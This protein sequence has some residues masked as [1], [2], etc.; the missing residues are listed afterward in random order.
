MVAAPRFAILQKM[1]RSFTRHFLF[2]A[3]LLLC[4]AGLAQDAATVVRLYLSTQQESIGLSPRD[5]SDWVVT[6]T[7]TDK[8]ELTFV[9]IQ[10]QV[11]GLPVFGAVANFALREGEVIVF[12]DRLQRGLIARTPPAVPSLDA[13]TALQRAATE[14][15]LAPG[16]VRVVQEISATEFELL[17]SGISHDPIPAR[18]IYQPDKDGEIR[19]AWRLIIRSV[20][21]PNWWDLA[22]DAITGEIIRSN[23]LIVHCSHPES[24]S[25][26]PYDA[27]NDL[28]LPAVPLA[29]MPM[30]GS[31]YR[32]FPFPS[33]S[34]SHGPHV[35]VMD[36][37]DVDASPFGWHDTD[38]QPGGEFTTTRGNNVHAYED[39]ADLD[40]PGYS[41]DGGAAL[42]FDFPFTPPQAPINYLDASI[43]N[44]FH[45]CNVLHDVLHRYGFDEQSGNFQFYNY[46]GTG[47]GFDEVI[48]EAQ[49]GG[50]MNNA[51][52]GTP[53]D[54]SNG[55]MQMYLW[56]TSGD[57]TLFV[58]SPASID[59]VYEN[60]VA[61]FGPPLPE[62]PITADVVL[63]QDAV[64]PVND[65]CEQIQNAAELNG[66]IA[67]V[68]RGQCTFISKVEALQDAGAIAV[69]IVNNVPGPPVG[70][71]GTGG[72]SI[73]IPTVMIS[74]ANGLL[75]KNAL[76]E[77]PVNAT[78]AG[79]AMED[80]RD[81]GFDNGIIAHEYGHG[82]SNR[83]TGGGSDVG[84]LW[85]EEQM[86]EGWSDYLGMI[87]TML[88]GD[89]A[90][91]PRGVGTFV[92]NQST[93][94]QGIRPAP[95]TTDL[96]V[97]GYTYG[98]T[99]DPNLSQP[100]G[101][102]FVWATMLWDL[103]WALVGQYGLDLDMY[104]GTSGNNMALQLVMDGMKL[105]PCNPG[106]V[107][108]RDA[109]LLAD[110]L[111]NNGANACL[112]WNVFAA[113]GLG[114]SA[115]QG[116]TGSRFDQVEAYDLPPA[117][118]NVA[119]E[120]ERGVAR[121]FLLMPNPTNDQVT[122][123]LGQAFTVDATLRVLGTDGREVRTMSIRA[124][125]TTFQMDVNGLAPA[126]YIVE[127][128][129]ADVV[130]KERLVVQ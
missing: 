84:C 31:G 44:L 129:V 48:A 69:I 42:S 28:Q 110:E 88:P 87:L 67:L 107:D 15:G 30:D 20:N 90:M 46:G 106:F 98:D 117:C 33:E 59:G 77:G 43:T 82:V 105:Q 4:S 118:I 122:L 1:H 37:A 121:E 86:G 23:D 75:I 120:E 57:S 5:A 64:A 19:L 6:S 112:I 73:V 91:T 108:G 45:A 21:S 22:V 70:M 35:L 130:L 51:N 119:V 113:R 102:G 101:V 95:Y 83:L 103:T 85:N 2:A 27:M 24:T 100:H 47:F 10:Q 54:G 128:R 29:P 34:P 52:F 93:D 36:P 3:A 114:Y 50:G 123:M 79:D 58:N 65:G 61:G 39:M 56:R 115:D 125:S 60:Q 74:M 89:Q 16:A 92:R 127:L 111:N 25:A 9:Y 116:S 32:V 66:K 68:D 38:G 13:V 62:V 78:L 72:E 80:L 26:R 14:L 49:D 97:N 94:G 124:G 126:L 7:S 71:G 53:E 63:V 41:P 18:L 55:R 109:I 99:N 17:P 8:K 104:A 12:G 40:S 76:L 96:A 81:S 11:N